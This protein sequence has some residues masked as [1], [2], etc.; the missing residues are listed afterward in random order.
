MTELPTL[1]ARGT[2]GVDSRRRALLGAALALA[3]APA[4]PQTW[5][6]RPQRWVVPF[7]AGG[8][9]DALTRVLAEALQGATRQT[10]VVDYIPGAAG[11]LG[12]QAV[13]RAPANGSTWLFIPQG[14]ITINATLLPTAPYKWDRDFRA[15][16]MLAYAPNVLA[17]HPDV[18]ARHVADL[19]RL[20][21]AQP[22]R[23][24]YGSPGIGSSLHLIAELLKREARIEILRAPYKGTTQAV[25]DLLGGQVQ[26]AFGALLTL[27]PHLR[28][29][30]LRALAV[31]TA[32]RSDRLPDTPTLIE[33]GYAIDVPSW[34]GV[35]A[36][37]GV[38]APV[39]E[40]AQVA[41]AA[42]MHTPAVRD[43]LAAQAL[44][45]VGSTPGD[46]AQQIQRETTT[47]ARVIRET[48]ITAEWS[49]PG[50]ALPPAP[51]R[52]LRHSGITVSFSCIARPGSSCRWSLPS[53]LNLSHRQSS[54]A[55][56]ITVP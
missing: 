45:P 43:K 52:T 24:T 3:A 17:V 12:I 6:D 46:F 32:K 48:N 34:Y 5:P 29:G 19:V 27:R 25:Q 37:A 28:S 23:L 26:I 10:I 47:W 14:N 11:N 2:A 22:G 50:A 36:P 51:R 1:P 33:S 54:T 8:V 56:T 4:W 42:T 9:L 18:P 35:M 13:A 30:K 7:P 41:L 39:V 40:R 49:P 38:S 15:V 55:G 31:T 53:P 21:K 44:Q 20:A 16:S